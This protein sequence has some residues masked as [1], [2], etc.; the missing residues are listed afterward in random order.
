MTHSSSFGITNAHD[1]FHEIVL[2]Q[3][4]DF[5]A[6][7]SSP[8]HALLAIIVAYHM[9]EWVPPGP[10]NKALPKV[11]EL[12]KKITN[13]TKHFKQKV[14]TRKQGGFSGGFSP[15]F[16][17]GFARSLRVM[18]PDGTEQSANVIL[19]QM[20]DFWTQQEINGAF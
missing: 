16:G 12:A 19:R 6:H 5:L 13:G 7:C 14:Q 3:H 4:E 9:F 18:L 15:A 17:D 20:V 8:R 2:P 11:F 10:S 1:F